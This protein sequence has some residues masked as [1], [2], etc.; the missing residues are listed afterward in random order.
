MYYDAEKFVKENIV[1]SF[2][3]NVTENNT[4]QGLEGGL[5]LLSHHLCTSRA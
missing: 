3:G 1:P 5:V 2:N 4:V